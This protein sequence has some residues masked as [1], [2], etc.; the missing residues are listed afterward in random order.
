MEPYYVKLREI[1]P[2]LSDFIREAQMM[3]KREAIPG[4]EAIHDIRVLMKKSRATLK[5]IE[6]QLDGEYIRRDI[7]ALREVGRKMCTWRE[8]SVLRKHLK[9]IKKEFPAL[10]PQLADNE[11]INLLLKKQDAAATKA[12]IQATDLKK[13]NDLLHNTG[14]RIR[15]LTMSNMDP[16]LLI[17]Q[18]ESTYDTVVDVYLT[19]RNNPKPEKLHEF[20]KRAKDFLYQLFFFRPLNPGLIKSLEKRLDSMTQS[21]GR[22][23]DLVQ[24]IKALDY[25]YSVNKHI[26]AMDELIVKVRDKQDR[27]LLKAWSDASKIFHPGQKL[28][29]LLGFKLLMI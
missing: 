26:P 9:E 21:I 14:F 5:L 15:F 23:N 2:A 27:Y 22:F 10:F 1:K 25:E 6:P 18:L 24:L 28:A 19:C 13:I 3:L 17:R 11:K 16:N 12:D 20:R 7:T 4:D 29:N 8:A